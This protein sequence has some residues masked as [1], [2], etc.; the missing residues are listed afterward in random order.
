[1]S[2][3]ENLKKNLNN[4]ISHGVAAWVNPLIDTAN[5]RFFF[6]SSACRPFGMVNLSPDTVNEGGAWGA[7]YRYQSPYV[8][9]FS[10]VHGWQK[11]GIPVLPVTGSMKEK[12][13]TNDYRSRFSHDKEEVHPGYHR[14]FLEDYR[15]QAE[16]TSTCRVGFH[17]YQFPSF[18][19][20]RET[21]I[22]LDLGTEIGPTEMSETHLEQTGPREL[23]G[24][25]VNAPT[26]RR[27]K[28]LKIF[29][30]IQLNRDIT[31]GN[32][33]KD[34]GLINFTTEE[35][36]EVL[37]KVALSYTSI[38]GAR[39]NLKAELD[40][41]DFDRV[42]KESSDEWDDW[43][44]RILVEGGT[45]AR[46]IKF[47]TDLYHSLLGRRIVSDIDGSYIDNTG[48]EPIVRKAEGYIHHNFDALWGSHWTLNILWPLVYPE[49]THHFVHTMMDMYRHGELIPRGPSGGNYTFVMTAP[50]STPFIV[51]AWQKGIQTFDLEEA[52]EGMMKNH[53]PQGLMAKA[54]YE[55]DTFI[56]GGAKYYLEK[57]FVPNDIEA[58]AFNAGKGATKTLEYAYMDWCLAQM[59]KALGKHEDFNRLMKRSQNYRNI[60]NKESGFFQS[61]LSDGSWVPDFDPWSPEGWVEG[62]GW[63]YLWYVPHDIPGLLGLMG[64]RETF[65]QRLEE[66]FE[67]AQEKDFICPHGEHALNYMD[68]GNQPCTGLVHLFHLVG[69]PDLTQK[70]LR[71]V[72]DACKS[73]ITPYGGYGGDED[74]GQMGT[75]NVLMAMGLFQETGGCE[76]NPVYQI[77]TPFFKRIEI[78][79]DSHYYSSDKLI[80]LCHGNPESEIYIERALFNG[81]M[82]ANLSITHEELTGGG[83]VELFLAEHGKEQ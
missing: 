60:W 13:Q 34:G 47:Y 11:A 79:L 14:V 3:E 65:V 64:G 74:Q 77:T 55:H 68:Y 46:T 48:P 16:L 49:V 40:H 45:E 71:K 6:F 43:L 28:P 29:F 9:F 23:T 81:K 4:P 15:I 78:V 26:I 17:R 37:M 33:K 21:G 24:F 80:I 61:R 18:L 54:G 56:G 20:D 30:V 75:L 51:S 70:W 39:K 35:S 27:P 62:N 7:G 44:G 10:H 58:R 63:Q 53:T 59:A 52:F 67:K 5:R 83:T 42:V 12:K 76:E 25:V 38:E 73:D 2:Q 36:R 66:M 1:M 69:R 50:T 19:K 8:C 31:L 72:V 22:L 57:G 32:W 41:W 82:L